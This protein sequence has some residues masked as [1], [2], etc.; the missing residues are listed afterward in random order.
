MRKDV[1][2]KFKKLFEQQKQSLLFNDKVVREDFLM[3]P[4]DRMDDA[5]QASVDVEQAL[6]L[7]LRNRE[8]LL[9]KKVDE[10]LLRIENG[11]F[12]ECEAC[13]EDIEIRRLEARPTATLCISCK[14]DQELREMSTADGR[15]HKSLGTELTRLY[16]WFSGSIKRGRFLI[17]PLFLF[18]IR[19]IADYIFI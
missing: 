9:L 16:F 19:Y 18:T 10:A 14:E 17:E 6:R 2:K 4:D 7:R 13:E 5:D 1:Q 8:T 11:T 15:K 12:G 3:S